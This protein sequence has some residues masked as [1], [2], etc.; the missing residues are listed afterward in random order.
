MDWFFFAG[1]EEWA[2]VWLISHLCINTSGFAVCYC[3]CY[4]HTYTDTQIHSHLHMAHKMAATEGS[5]LSDQRNRRT[6]T[7]KI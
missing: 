5:R 7:M 2:K 6:V 1:F 3:C 4:A